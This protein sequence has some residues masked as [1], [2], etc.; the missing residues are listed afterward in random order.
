[1][2]NYGIVP[3]F[4]G[5]LINSFKKSECFVTSLDVSLND[6]LQSYEMGLLLRYVRSDYFTVKSC[7][8]DS[9]FCAHATHQDLAKQFNDGMKQLQL[10]VNKS[11]QISL[12][13][14]SVNRKFLDEVLKERKADEQYELINIGSCGS[15]TIHGAF[16]TSAEWNIKQTLRKI[17]KFQNFPAR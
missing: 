12:D 16:K 2:K 1:M 5:L 7:Y 8:Y 15:H 6:D 14:L 11:L 3:Y 13:G 4:K 9:Q 10:Y 17:F